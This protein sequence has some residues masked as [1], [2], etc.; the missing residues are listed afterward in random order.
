MKEY[1]GEESYSPKHRKKRS[2]EHFR[3]EIT[4]TNINGRSDKVAFRTTAAL[5][6]HEFHCLPKLN[7]PEA[8]KGHVIKTA[9]KLVKNDIRLRETSKSHY[10]P[11]DDIS[12]V[13]KNLYFVPCSLQ[14]LLKSIFVE[15]EPNRKVASIGPGIM[16]AASPKVLMA[17]LQLVLRVQITISGRSSW[18]SLYLLLDFAQT[19]DGTSMFH[20]MGMIAVAT[21]KINSHKVIPRVK[22]TSGDVALN[23]RIE[24]HY[25]KEDI[26][27]LQSIKFEKLSDL[28]ITDAPG[29]V[30]LL[31]NISWQLRCLRHCEEI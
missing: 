20:G 22:I 18:F 10:S 24:I 7:Y 16:Q 15:E 27:S 14:I 19:L 5:I 23:S 9:A 2:L 11:I 21:P 13:D 3:D 4:I 31:C 8:D 26:F 30:D 29:K 25:Y 1:C 12:S 6:L 28:G 17:P